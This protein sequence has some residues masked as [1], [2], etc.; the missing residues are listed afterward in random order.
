MHFNRVKRALFY[1][2][3]GHPR[4]SFGSGILFYRTSTLPIGPFGTIYD[5]KLSVNSLKMKDDSTKQKMKG[6]TSY[7]KLTQVPDIETTDIL[8]D[9]ERDN[10][11][12]K[13]RKLKW[14]TSYSNMSLL[15]TEKRL[16]FIVETF[17]SSAVPVNNMLATAQQ[18]CVRPGADAILNIKE[19]VYD[20]IVQY[21]D[22]EGYPELN[23]DFNEANI[24]DLVLYTIG[25]IISSV[26]RFTGRN[27]LLRRE[28][29]IV[30]T[31]S[32]TGGKEEFVVIDLIS[33]ME[34]NFVLIIE[35]KRSSLAEAIKQCLLSLKDMRDN[36]GA[37]KVY[38][39][40]TIGESWRMLSYDGTS[41]ETTQKIHLLFEGMEQEKERW[42]KDYSILVD[43]IYA[44]L[45]VGGIVKKDVTV[46]A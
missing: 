4:Q 7:S 30:S 26:K 18:E 10:K 38:G 16:G 22:I 24:S 43:C 37:G 9:S 42:M 27:I 33:I 1:L 13:K 32:E 5:R 35:A 28:K 20:A 19:K 14:F 39:F 41:F 6:K 34:R 36:N 44:V 15:D 8:S 29:E 2:I 23:P 40:I 31:D 12:Q 3:N 46:V 45:S 21:L 11:N 17:V 25:P